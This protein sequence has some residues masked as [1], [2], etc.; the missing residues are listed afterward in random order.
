M[1][2][3]QLREY[4]RM[5]YP[6]EN[7]AN[8]WKEFKNLKND[9]NGKEKNDIISYV[10]GIANMDGGNLVI[11]VVDQTLEIVGTDTYN[12][13]TDVAKLRIKD[14]CANVPTDGLTID[15][16]ITDDTQKTVWVIHIPKHLPRLP[17]YA[18]SKP[19]QRIG[20]SL[21]DI[22]KGRMDA[23]LF[24]PVPNDTDWTAEILPQAT[25]DSLDPEAIKKAREGYK[26]Y[27]PKNAE[28][29]DQWDDV[30]FL[31]KA[32]ITIDGK[33][34]RA[35]LI[36]LGKEENEWMINPCVCKVRWCLKTLD[37]RNKDYEIYSM[38]LILAVDELASNVRNTKV[39]FLRP[40]SMQPDMPK[41]YDDFTLREPLCNCIA[42]QLWTA[43]A[44][45]EV[46]EFEDDR[47]IF[48]NYGP[49]I[50]TSVM[51]VVLNDSP[52]S[53]YL[54]PFLVEAMRNVDL[55]DTEG[56]GIKHLFELQ[57]DRLFPMPEYDLNDG[58]VK[59]TITGH[60][61]NKA[62]ADLLLER[63]D[64][65]LEEVMHIDCIAK[66]HPERLTS[67]Q[68]QKL[69]DKELIV[70]NGEEWIVVGDIPSTNPPTNPS[71][72][73]PTNP[74]TNLVIPM[75]VKRL[76]DLMDNG[77][78]SLSQL[79]TLVNLKDRRSFTLN[80]LNPALEINVIVLTHPEQKNHRDQKYKKV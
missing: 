75:R 7:E 50:P 30:T 67:A 45:I 14:Q 10:S 44:R 9:F 32:H 62:F 3:N 21:I 35:A 72:N 13:D 41:R 29:C 66:K 60:V 22:T 4:I 77:E 5:N 24:E 43:G 2:E 47:L 40:G 25:I 58:K 28:L 79:M 6:K 15:E 12:Y 78:Y 42:H 57:R 76:L 17:V 8:E 1:T 56:G 19:F 64:L 54:N 74:S 69:A 59:V 63:Q 46:V 33:I 23:I 34:T 61:D 71:T 65:S 27:K 51:Q 55:I 48:Q 52:S 26:R 73:P 11:G 16:Y 53:Y 68:I 18:H 70:K 38:P 80:Y 39:R 37:N 36:L 49:F 20:S 31:N